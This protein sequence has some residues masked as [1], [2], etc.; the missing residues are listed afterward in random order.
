MLFAVGVGIPLGFFAAKWH[1]GVFDQSS[2]FIPDRGLDPGLLPRDPAR[3]TSSKAAVGKRAAADRRDERGRASD[4]LLRPRRDHHQGLGD[5][6]GR[7]QGTSCCPRSPWASI[8]LAIITRITRASVLDVQNEDYVRTARAKGLPPRTVDR[9]HVRNALP[10]I[11]TIIG[12][13]T[14]L[15]LS[16]A[17]LTETVFAFPGWIGS[18]TRS[19]I[20][21]CSCRADPLPR[22]RLRDRQPDRGHPVRDH[23]SANPLFMSVAEI[24]A[25]EIQLE[26]PSALARRLPP[27]DPTRARSSGSSSSSCSSS[28]RSS[29]R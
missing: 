24:E 11:S 12:L 3:S 20:A 8:P 9:R 27:T 18:A 6:Q 25:V 29:R 4:E 22:I 7:A 10:P 26:A 19:S 5:A 21:T 1:G 15:L 17:I 2:L 16:G 23:Q 13:Q 14:G 28:R